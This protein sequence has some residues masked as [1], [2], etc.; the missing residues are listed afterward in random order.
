MH[1]TTRPGTQTY[2]CTHASAQTH[3]HRQICNTYCL[4]TAT[5]VSRTR[6]SVTLYVCCLS[7]CT[8]HSHISL[9]KHECSCCLSSCTLHSHISLLKHEC[10]CCLSCC[11]LHSHI[12]L[13]KHE[14]SCC[15][16]VFS[17]LP[18]TVRSRF[19]RT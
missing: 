1:T 4:S 2:A 14:C 15:L 16:P 9:L 3:T 6:L 11:T 13:L 7:C 8:L 19:V 18:R 5:V 17:N 10:S 12:S